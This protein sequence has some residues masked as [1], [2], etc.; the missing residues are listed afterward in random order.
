[1]SGQCAPCARLAAAL[2]LASLAAGCG[3]K[4]DLYLPEPPPEPAGPLE[5]PGADT[6]EPDDAP[7]P[8]GG[9]E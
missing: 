2:L 3:M 4:G 9:T 6:L 5:A 8:D 7:A 1:M